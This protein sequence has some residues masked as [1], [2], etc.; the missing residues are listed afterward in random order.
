MGRHIGRGKENKGRKVREG[1]LE[2]ERERKRYN[3]IYKGVIGRVREKNEESNRERWMG[4][5][6]KT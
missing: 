6:W 2:R 5:E 3:Y 4:K 1:G